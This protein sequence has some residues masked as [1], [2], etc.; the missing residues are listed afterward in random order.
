MRPPLWNRAWNVVAL[1]RCQNVSQMETG[2]R[3][4]RPNEADGGPFHRL[5]SEQESQHRSL[6]CHGAAVRYRDPCGPRLARSCIWRAGRYFK[7]CLLLIA[8]KY[9]VPE[10]AHS[11]RS[12]R[13][14]YD[15]IESSRPSS[16]GNDRYSRCQRRRL[17]LNRVV[18][19][20]AQGLQAVFLMPCPL[21]PRP[22]AVRMACYTLYQIDL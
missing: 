15:L 10:R 2:M 5:S 13:I 1:R 19:W 8:T 3:C 11:E 20:F 16:C 14:S 7:A 9:Q 22:P 17:R 21:P 12:L 4:P 18:M 6:A